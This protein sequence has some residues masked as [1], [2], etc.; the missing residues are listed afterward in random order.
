MKQQNRTS[1]HTWEME[2]WSPTKTILDR[3]TIEAPD[4]HISEKQ[5]LSWLD[6]IGALANIIPKLFYVVHQYERSFS[7]HQEDLILNEIFKYKGTTN[8]FVVDIGAGD[9]IRISNS[10]FFRQL[11]W[12]SLLVDGNPGKVG[13]KQGVQKHWITLENIN[14]ILEENDVPEEMDL[15]SLDI[16]GNDYWILEKILAS[17]K[18]RVIVVE[19]NGAYGDRDDCMPY[20][21]DY[22]HKKERN[23][24]HG[25]S[26]PAA[27]RLGKENGYVH[28]CTVR[29]TNLILIRE[30]LDK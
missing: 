16:D 19:I 12:N 1:Q 7:Q 20:R 28:A 21:E 8:E 26:M 24:L 14:S 6:K 11:G 13:K 22:N 3:L 5:S 10:L 25:Q 15:L 4:T 29:G 9:G 2:S 17:Y 18:P 27:I 23:P 30:D